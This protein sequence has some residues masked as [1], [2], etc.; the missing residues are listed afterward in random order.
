MR[1]HKLSLGEGACIPEAGAGLAGI[2]LGAVGGRGGLPCCGTEKPWGVQF[3]VPLCDDVCLYLCVCVCSCTVLWQCWYELLPQ[4]CPC[5]LPARIWEDGC[6]WQAWDAEQSGQPSLGTLSCVLLPTTPGHAWLP[7][8]VEGGKRL[9]SQLCRLPFCGLVLVYVGVC[10]CCVPSMWSEREQACSVDHRQTGSTQKWLGAQ[11][12]EPYR[13]WVQTPET[14]ASLADYFKSLSLCT[15]LDSSTH[16]LELLGEEIS[17]LSQGLRTVWVLHSVN[18]QCSS[19]SS[20]SLVQLERLF[21]R[22]MSPAER[23][24][25]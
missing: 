4:A 11:T 20:H 21:A 8:G 24:G 9:T 23:A 6:T 1:P 12:L 5:L 16:L 17:R 13:A 18:S 2:T 10:F 7:R 14:A 3:C 19:H 15:L 25:V 22:S